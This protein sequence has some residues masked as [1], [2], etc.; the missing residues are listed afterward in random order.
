MAEATNGHEVDIYHERQRLQMCAIHAVN[1][2]FQGTQIVNKE[3]MNEVCKELSPTSWLNPH[4]SALGVGNYDINAIMAVLSKRGYDIIWF[5][6]RRYEESSL[7]NIYWNL[8][9]L[10]IEDEGLL[11]IFLLLYAI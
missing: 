4:M 11:C 6:K 10:K 8:A 2:L 9:N 7:S 1:N 3:E 5:D